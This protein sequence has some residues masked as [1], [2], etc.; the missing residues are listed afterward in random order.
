[1]HRNGQTWAIVS[2]N[3]AV[4]MARRPNR[5]YYNRIR[6]KRLR[7]YLV[8]RAADNNYRDVPIFCPIRATAATKESKR[9]ITK[10]NRKKT[11]WG[12]RDER[13]AS[14]GPRMRYN[15]ITI[16]AMKHYT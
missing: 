14:K 6:K 15:A 11:R 12:G 8:V 7:S 4:K 3:N 10:T 5:S 9:I 1:M 2:G 16:N 13:S